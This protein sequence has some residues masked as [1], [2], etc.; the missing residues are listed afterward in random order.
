MRVSFLTVALL[1]SYAT[2]QSAVPEIQIHGAV[3]N[4]TDDS[5]ESAGFAAA[6]ALNMADHPFIAPT[7]TD[8]RTPCPALNSLAN[9]GFLPR[10]G[11]AITPDALKDSL[12]KVYGLTFALSTG[13]VESGWRSCGKFEAGKKAPTDL[14]EFAQHNKIEHDAS[15]AHADVAPGETYAPVET[16]QGLLQDFVSRSADGQFLTMDDVARVRVEREDALPV[17][18]TTAGVIAATGEGIL[19]LNRIG[20][21]EKVPVSDVQTFLGE[22]RLPD[23]YT[24]PKGTMG[25]VTGGVLVAKLAKNMADIRG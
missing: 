25:F 9:H 14:I 15:L 21:S 7:A 19:L 10:D 16:D 1:T 18:L 13:L 17:P 8:S 24:G 20:D 22:S 3:N 4:G 5:N 6:A 11:K 2:A 12:R 23:S